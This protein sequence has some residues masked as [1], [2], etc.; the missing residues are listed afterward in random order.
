VSQSE[1]D[2]TVEVLLEHGVNH[3]DTAASYGG[4]VRR[5][6]PWPQRHPNHFFLATKTEERDYNA[7]NGVSQTPHDPE[8]EGPA[9]A[10]PLPSSVT[11]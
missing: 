2:T 6:A 3:I 8:L 10:R 11:T 7:G 9:Y 5:I 4:S 1:A